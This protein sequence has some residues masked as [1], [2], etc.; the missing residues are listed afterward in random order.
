[1]K[2]VDQCCWAM[3]MFHTGQ[4]PHTPHETTVALVSRTPR[5]HNPIKQCEQVAA[6][7]LGVV[8]VTIKRHVQNDGFAAEGCENM[9]SKQ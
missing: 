7:G 4:A 2:P 3:H 5:K 9:R 8:A 1:M 6:V